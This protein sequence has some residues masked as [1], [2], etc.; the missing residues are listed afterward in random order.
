MNYINYVNDYIY[1]MNNLSEDYETFKKLQE[2]VDEAF[3]KALS[4]SEKIYKHFIL[5]KGGE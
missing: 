1:D 3:D 5:N 2:D 4:H